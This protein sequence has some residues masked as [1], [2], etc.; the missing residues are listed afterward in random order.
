MLS[1]YYLPSEVTWNVLRSLSKSR[2][3]FRLLFSVLD[4]FATFSHLHELHIDTAQQTLLKALR[5]SS[6][7]FSSFF[8]TIFYWI[9]VEISCFMMALHIIISVSSYLNITK[10]FLEQKFRCSRD[11]LF[12]GLLNLKKKTYVIIYFNVSF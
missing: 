9:E 10:A 6:H 7:K 3:T 11:S 1:T 4:L 5:C 2:V 12:I 8:V